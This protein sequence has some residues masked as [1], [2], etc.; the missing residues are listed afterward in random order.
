MNLLDGDH[1]IPIL[2]LVN[3]LAKGL[4]LPQYLCGLAGVHRHAQADW[5]GYY[6][7]GLPLD[8]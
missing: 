8:D 3:P 1:S 6:Q 7:I 5:W 4:E 2:V